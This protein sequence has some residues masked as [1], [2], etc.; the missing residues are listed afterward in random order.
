MCL[1]VACKGDDLALQLY[2]QGGERLNYIIQMCL[3]GSDLKLSTG[4]LARV[5]RAIM[6]GDRKANTVDPMLEDIQGCKATTDRNIFG[7][8]PHGLARRKA[9][10]HWCQGV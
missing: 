8:S 3:A 4:A 9:C 5:L 10:K 2:K 1:I 6:T 7:I